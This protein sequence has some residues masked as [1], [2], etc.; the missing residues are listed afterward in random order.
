MISAGQ[1]YRAPARRGYRYLKIDQVR[2]RDAAAYALCREVN[3][4]GE[5]VT[6][7]LHGVYRGHQFAVAL[8]WVVGGGKD[9]W[10][11]PVWY[12]LFEAKNLVDDEATEV[13]DV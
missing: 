8:T 10:S 7:W 11:M 13:D 2:Q 1:I 3:A 5:Y 4:K 6:G 9:S 12:E